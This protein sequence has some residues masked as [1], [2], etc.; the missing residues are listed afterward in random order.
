M[1]TYARPISALPNGTNLSRYLICAGLAT[2]DRPI[3]DIAAGLK[4]TP[5]VAHAIKQAV[6]WRTK[7]D[8]SAGTTTDG[9]WAGDLAEPALGREV[10]ELSQEFSAYDQLRTRLRRVPFRVLT[11]RQIGTSAGG[12]WVGHGAAVPLREL[13]FD[14]LRLDPFN[15]G[16]MV[17]VSQELLKIGNA[18]AELTIRRLVLAGLG[19]F[20]DQQFFDPTVSGV[21]GGENPPSITF[22]ATAITSSGSSA[23]QI[24]TDLSAMLAAIS[25][26]GHRLAF[27]MRPLTY[28]TIVAKLAGAGTTVPPGTLLGIPVVL[29]ANGPRQITLLDASEIL[30]ADD[31]EFEV[32]K[33]DEASIE[34]ED[35][36]SNASEA[37]GSP[38]GPSGSTYVHMYQTNCVALKAQRL[39]SWQRARD[40]AV[41]Y[42]TVSY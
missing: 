28:Y 22:G 9:D 11:V 37:G 23:S 30:Y 4:D 25:T 6:F 24:I 7:G 36:P 33:S 29:S 18:A 26:T 10:L 8:I 16:T 21:P 20:I 19:K 41:S 32:Q 17:V 12:A 3:A 27:A 15:A 35:G 38:T 2:W 34:M 5:L 42:M 13:A 40:G 39:L 31:G 14:Q 1:S